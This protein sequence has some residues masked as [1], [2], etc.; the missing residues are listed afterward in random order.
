MTP[1]RLILPTLSLTAPPASAGGAVWWSQPDTVCIP[2]ALAQSA[3]TGSWCAWC[4]QKLREPGWAVG[5]GGEGRG[6]ETKTFWS[7]KPLL[8]SQIWASSGR[9]LEDWQGALC[10]DTPG[11]Q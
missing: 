8:G 11:T 4:R 2:D 9:G 5:A 10:L 1:L 3:L 7:L 6:T